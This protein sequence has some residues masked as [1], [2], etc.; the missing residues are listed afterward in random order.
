MD[1]MT[2]EVQITNMR[3]F[4]MKLEFAILIYIYM[5]SHILRMYLLFINQSKK[6]VF[7]IYSFH[8]TYVLLN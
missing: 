4:I 8:A 3:K 2:K 1:I 6:N 7:I 5:F